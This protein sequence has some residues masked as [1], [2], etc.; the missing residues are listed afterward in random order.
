MKIWVTAF[1]YAS[2][3]GALEIPDEE[4][5]EYKKNEQAYI[6]KHLESVDFDKDNLILDYR[7]TDFDF[8]ECHELDELEER[9][10]DERD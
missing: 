7:G 1:P 10:D 6:E 8:E 5:S 4:V 3:T 2:V 9:D